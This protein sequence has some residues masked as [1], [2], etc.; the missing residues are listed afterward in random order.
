[1]VVL[2]FTALYREVFFFYLVDIHRLAEII[3]ALV[4]ITQYNWKAPKTAVFKMTIKLHQHLCWCTQEITLFPK[5]LEHS[6]RQGHVKELGLVTTVCRFKKK[7]KNNVL[8]SYFTQSSFLDTCIVQYNITEIH[9]WSSVQLSTVL[10]EC[11][12][13][14][15]TLKHEQRQLYLT[16]LLLYG[17]L[18]G[19]P[20]N[21]I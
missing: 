19:K 17:Y 8:T 7:T 9:L 6:V 20:Q 1:M 15:L 16:V 13:G 18:C 12:K 2:N 5:M 11:W 14:D 21:T 3:E 10:V 4:R